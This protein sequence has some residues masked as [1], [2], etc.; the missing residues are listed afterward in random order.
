MYGS[1]GQEKRVLMCPLNWG[2]GHAV[3]C[4]PIAH[5]FMRQGYHV[6]FASDGFPLQLL[7]LEF[8]DA[9][10]FELPGYNITYPTNNMLINVGRKLVSFLGAIRRENSAVRRIVREYNYDIIV[11]D[12]R[13]GCFAKE[14]YNI[15]ITH[16]VNIITPGGV[17]DPAVNKF[18]HYYIRKFDECW[19]PDFPEYPGLTG[20]LGHDH[21]LEHCH[22]IGPVSRFVY[23]DRSSVYGM[24]GLLSGPE[25]QRS[26]L[27]KLLCAQLPVL[28]FR[29]ALVSGV[30]SGNTPDLSKEGMD[31]FGYL[32]ST[33]LN[34][35]MLESEIIVCRGGYTTIMDLVV[36]NKKAI[37]IPTPGQTEQE[38]LTK[39]YADNGFFLRQEQDAVNLSTAMERIDEFTGMP[40]GMNAGILA[41]IIQK[42]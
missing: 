30:I 20:K 28:S 14:T 5:E 34:Q 16:Q 1:T 17:F 25:P 35:L 41:G 9:Q 42:L 32:T 21:D 23:E 13:F 29:T 4:I 18:N 8:P 3:R 19:I 31:H 24:T 2:L 37:C 7:R 10:F 6:D 22:Y 38:Y 15:F 26:R 12:N 33:R 11:S 36:L 39:I 40:F 27:E